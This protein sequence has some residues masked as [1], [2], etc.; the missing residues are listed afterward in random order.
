M[1]TISVKEL[2]RY[3]DDPHI[4]IIDLRSEDEYRRGHVKNAVN[5]PQGEF[6]A[7]PDRAYRT[8][9]LYC[10]RGVQSMIT[11]RKLE[12]MGYRTKS[13]VGGYRACQGEK[14]W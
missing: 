13:V 9:I 6:R 5:V 1:E 12:Q 2:E 14:M 10:E 3:V 4:L 7:A 8:I 11:A